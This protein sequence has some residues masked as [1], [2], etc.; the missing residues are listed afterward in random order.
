[1]FTIAPDK[2]T[3]RQTAIDGSLKILLF[4]LAL[5][6][7]QNPHGIIKP[8]KLVVGPSSFV[9]AK[10]APAW[11]FTRP[12]RINRKLRYHRGTMTFGISNYGIIEVP[13]DSQ[14]IIKDCGRVEIEAKTT[15]EHA[16][17]GTVT[18]T[19]A[20][21]LHL[22]RGW[23]WSEVCRAEQKKDAVGG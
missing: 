16:R 2:H 21:R 22:K 9:A 3:H 23:R 17:T 11:N 6:L 5:C 8:V 4:F 19:L 20:L 13:Q 7:P 1:M 15:E 18:Q 10:P 12:W 14:F